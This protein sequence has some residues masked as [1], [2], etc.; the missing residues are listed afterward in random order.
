MA[1]VEEKVKTNFEEKLLPAV[2]AAVQELEERKRDV[3]NIVEECGQEKSLVRMQVSRSIAHPY[4]LLKDF[5]KYMG[6]LVE[7]E[8]AS[9]L[10]L[11][12]GKLAKML[13]QYVQ[14][15][16]GIADKVADG[17]SPANTQNLS[18]K[19]LSSIANI[20]VFTSQLEHKVAQIKEAVHPILQSD[21]FFKEGDHFFQ[22]TDGLIQDLRRK[23]RKNFQDWEDKVKEEPVTLETTG[24][25]M[26]FDKDGKLVV[27]YSD[28]LVNLLRQARQLCAI[29]YKIP[30]DVDAQL[31]KAQKLY[32]SGTRLKQVAGF[33]NRIGE[34]IVESQKKLLLKEASDFEEKV[35]DGGKSVNDD[36]PI[37]WENPDQLDK[38]IDQLKSA[39][40]R[41]TQKN[42]NLQRA[43]ES[44]SDIVVQL[45]GTDLVRQ[46]EQ[47]KKK[48]G[49]M[50][51][52][53]K[54]F[55]NETIA[56]KPAVQDW[57]H[58]WD[59]QLFKAL[60]FQYKQG[61]ESCHE[62]LSDMEAKLKFSEKDK[63]L[64][65]E[66]TFEEIRQAYYKKLSVFIDIPRRFKGVDL[67]GVSGSD[68]FS[69]I[70]ARNAQAQEGEKAGLVVVFQQAEKLFKK[71]ADFA[72]SQSSWAALGCIDNLQK[73]VE[74]KMTAVEDYEYNFRTLRMRQADA[75]KLPSEKR[76][77][78]I[79]VDATEV[80]TKIKG[81]LDDFHKALCKALIESARSDMEEL[82]KWVDGSLEAL[83]FQIQSADDMRKARKNF[84]DILEQFQKKKDLKSTMESK[85]RLITSQRE[86]APD[87]A[88]LMKS[89]DDLELRFGVHQDKMNEQHEQ[90][91]ANMGETIKRI[92]GEITGFAS[93][94]KDFQ[95]EMSSAGS[96][97]GDGISQ[98]AER[99]A[100]YQ[101]EWAGITEKAEECKRDC[102]MFQMPEPS[103][104]EL[105][106]IQVEFEKAVASFALY[107]DYKKDMAEHTEKTWLDVRDRLHEVE[108][109]LAKWAKNLTGRTDDAVVREMHLE[110]DRLR[111]NVPF[112]KFVKGEGFTQDHWSKLFELLIP[113]GAD[114]RSK[115]TAWFGLEEG[116]VPKGT[117]EI[118]KKA[119]LQ[120]FLDNSHI[121]AGELAEFKNLQARALAEMTIREAFAELVSWGIDATFTLLEHKDSS[122]GKVVPL[123]KEWKDVLTQVGDHQ[124]QLQAMRDSPYF[125]KFAAE[126]D[127][128]DKKLSTL[129]IGLNDLNSVQRKWL[130]LEPIFGRGALPHEQPRFKKV[131]D[132]FREIMF[133]I[134]KEP[135]VVEFA[136][137]SRNKLQTTRPIRCPTACCTLHVFHGETA[138]MSAWCEILVSEE[139]LYIKA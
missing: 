19:N 5:S 99:V 81:L 103:F 20:L 134:R 96:T 97:D 106:S 101:A 54:Q 90:A 70:I 31:N 127:D 55:D 136:G 91:K 79:K 139:T 71:L 135:R 64:V 132:E 22:A 15:I 120:L 14:I 34:E 111:K 68:I 38:Y 82:Q 95:M 45:M 39:M 117:D 21:D 75:N 76:I 27:H 116:Q 66:P 92:R 108:D 33:Y 112:L 2:Q 87:T 113:K 57:V 73:F 13:E 60:D 80:T 40:D 86:S 32:H 48:I 46:Q 26:S 114:M 49:D 104:A 16:R 59:H 84:G 7:P 53:I 105:D 69:Q 23:T 63:K 28:D 30:K 9:K 98:R 126:A 123:I 94:W 52:I 121:V 77:D 72:E 122:A 107:Q 35:Q 88:E 125:Q 110:I 44:L 37:T 89:W 74:T 115:A 47:W 78:C 4:Q 25:V 11:Q 42:R 61:L 1:Q 138:C 3:T 130:Y 6:L 17:L 128:W 41:L 124:A 102:A 29:G 129:G 58:H 83:D 51:A 109:C 12:R 56:G 10:T 100:E 93:R 133:E 50:R 62:I 24:K 65:F 137:I 118:K 18:G 8:I 131:D 85:C 43:H 119:R 67:P 36:K